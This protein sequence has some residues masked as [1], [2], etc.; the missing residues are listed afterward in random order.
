M[1]AMIPSHINVKMSGKR[2]GF[3]YAQ[4][5]P[6]VLHFLDKQKEVLYRDVLMLRSHGCEG[7]V[8]RRTGRN[9]NYDNSKILRIRM[10][11]FQAVYFYWIPAQG[12]YDEKV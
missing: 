11:A 4:K 8:P 1:R 3:I 5:R 7:A 6:W 10:V 2:S 12:R 9:Q